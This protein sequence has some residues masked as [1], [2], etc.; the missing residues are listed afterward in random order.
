MQA[1]PVT[2]PVAGGVT[3]SEA[4]SGEEHHLIT[5][6]CPDRKGLLSQ[7]SEHL[8]ALQVD[9]VHASVAT[10][11]ESGHV[12]DAFAVRSEGPK[13]SS[14]P[15]PDTSCCAHSPGAPSLAGPVGLLER[16]GGRP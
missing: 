8:R 15:C 7:L 12:V 4:D 6:V 11:T 1:A 13:R 2:E 5:V 16:T 3:I 10:D 14:L 9:V